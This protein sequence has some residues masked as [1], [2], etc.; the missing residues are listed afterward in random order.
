MRKALGLLTKSPSFS[1]PSMRPWRQ[2]ISCWPLTDLAFRAWRS[3]MTKPTRVGFDVPYRARMD[4]HF[5]AWLSALMIAYDTLSWRFNE[6]GFRFLAASDNAN[7][8]LVETSFDGRRS[9][10]TRASSSPRDLLKLPAYNFYEILR[11]LGDRHGT[12]IEGS[13]EY[14]PNSELF[15]I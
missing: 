5:A 2:L 9:I 15:H 6:V 3:L 7:Q 8:Q 1:M 14:F 12:F 13:E 10:M 11:L 4:T